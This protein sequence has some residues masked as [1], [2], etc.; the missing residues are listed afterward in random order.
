[1]SLDIVRFLELP[2]RLRRQVYWHLDGQFSRLK[3]PSNY[4]LFSNDF[5]QFK[6]D[7]L[8]DS[9]TQELWTKA[10]KYVI[11]F[12][13][14]DGFQRV[15]S[16]YASILRYDPILMDF[17]RVNSDLQD[18]SGGLEWI[19]VDGELCVALFSRGGVLQAWYTVEEYRMWIQDDIDTCMTINV[20]R[21]AQ[22][23]VPEVLTKLSTSGFIETV[24]RVVFGDDE[25]LEQNADVSREAEG[26]AVANVISKLDDFKS[27]QDLEIIGDPLFERVLNFHGSRDYPGQVVGYV[28]KRRVKRIRVREMVELGHTRNFADLSRWEKL[29]QLEID[30]VDTVDLNY[31]IL[32]SACRFFILRHI[33]R[34]IWWFQDGVSFL[35]EESW[36]EGTGTVK[37]VRIKRMRNADAAT[38]KYRA[39]IWDTF[40][41]LNYLKLVNVNQIVG[42]IRVPHAL[43]DN[44]RIQIINSTHLTTPLT[45]EII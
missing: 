30:T 12:G 13:Y 22:S 23:G 37:N 14:I 3:P 16:L 19:D 43:Y 8:M 5:D 28:V 45:V 25:D 20:E 10:Q 40:S 32:P 4:E 39:L 38:V 44:G 9:K 17:L 2:L 27:L 7:E 36:E 11:N 29:V 15:W 1:M 6:S 35:G 42:Q 18:E 21:L 26:S 41:G 31:L 33:H 24:T 34:L